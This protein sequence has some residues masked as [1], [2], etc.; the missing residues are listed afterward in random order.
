MNKFKLD[1][2]DFVK[3]GEEKLYRLVALKDF[4][5]VKV[6][7]KGGYISENVELDQK[8]DSWIYDEAGHVF[9]SCKISKGS[10]IRGPVIIRD[11]IIEKATIQTTSCLQIINSKIVDSNIDT[12]WGKI[13]SADIIFTVLTTENVS[14]GCNSY[15]K[16]GY[17]SIILLN[18]KNLTIRRNVKILGNTYSNYYCENITI[19]DYSYLID[20]S[21]N[22]QMN[23]DIH[24]LNKTIARDKCIESSTRYYNTVIYNIRGSEIPI[25]LNLDTK[26]VTYLTDKRAANV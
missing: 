25:S 8:D 23:N 9:N 21:I 19:D 24:I 3:Y 6:G 26:T 2:E 17:N 1:Y 7:D 10:E 14:I 16:G 5:D 4:A 18:T 15:L 20:C 13:D 11:S 12:K 22:T